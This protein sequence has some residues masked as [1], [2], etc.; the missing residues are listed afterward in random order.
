MR[1]YSRRCLGALVSVFALKADDGRSDVRC[2]KCT[3]DIA[4]FATHNGPDSRCLGWVI[5]GRIR[6][7]RWIL[8]YQFAAKLTSA[9]AAAASAPAPNFV[10][11]DD[12]ESRC[13]FCAVQ[14]HTI[15]PR[16]E[17]LHDRTKCFLRFRRWRKARARTRTTATICQ[18]VRNVRGMIAVLCSF[19]H[20][21]ARLIDS[22]HSRLV[23]RVNIA[24]ILFF[25]FL[26]TYDRGI[27][28]IMYRAVRLH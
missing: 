5:P 10:A 24:D 15:A 18:V 19:P 6:V 20:A 27:A 21:S 23:I 2:K 13:D 26:M 17:C 1:D 16:G 3:R 28:G 7:P 11:S 22:Y 8:R 14:W 12:F 25:F 4:L 9:R